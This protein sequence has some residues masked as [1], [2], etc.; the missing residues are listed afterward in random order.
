MNTI[1]NKI[2]HTSN[3]REFFE[4][5]RSFSPGED[6]LLNYKWAHRWFNWLQACAEGDVYTFQEVLQGKSGAEVM[7]N[8]ASFFMMSSY[9]YL[10]L[11]GH[12]EIEAAAIDAIKKYG[13]GSGGVRLL[14]GTNELHEQLEKDISTFKGTEAAMVFSSG[15]MANMAVIAALFSKNDLVITDEY[16]HRSIADAIKLAG[17]IPVIFRHNDPESLKEILS[18]APASVRKLIIVEGVYS[19]DGDIC[20]LPEIVQLKEEY[21]AL[22]M[23]DEAHSLGVLGENGKGVNYHFNIPSEKIDIFTGSLSKAIPSNGGFIAAREKDIVYLKHGG[24]PYMFSAAS[25]PAN[26]AAAIAA[27]QIM[28]QENYR[29]NNLWENARL[30]VNG[31]NALGFDTG[32]SQSPIVPLITGTNE[33]AFHLS[34]KLFDEG[35]ITS[36]VIYPAVPAAKARLRLCCTA[37]HTKEML[38]NFIN[39]VEEVFTR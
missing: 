26:N 8:N 19:M 39:T 9:D 12:P 25:T 27:L 33:S 13:T 1:S 7:I 6:Q 22:L 36:A 31:L 38:E 14:T 23:I 15:Y 10:G 18:N 11:I 17:I 4:N 21:N 16:I 34:K 29:L 3:V 20:N 28:Q 30:L 24:A 5:N 32:L 37:N 35:Y 2:S